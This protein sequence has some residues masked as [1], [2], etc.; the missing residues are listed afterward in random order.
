MITSRILIPTAEQKLDNK[1]K[2][3]SIDMAYF[4]SLIAA[5]YER[6]QSVLVSDRLWPM[7]GSTLVSLTKG[8]AVESQ[9]SKRDKDALTGLSTEITLSHLEASFSHPKRGEIFDKLSWAML[10]YLDY[11]CK[12]ADLKSKI[13][14]IASTYVLLN[15]ED[16]DARIF[17]LSKDY[18]RHIRA[19]VFL[20]PLCESTDPWVV[21]SLLSSSN[22]NVITFTDKMRDDIDANVYSALE[23]VN[24]FK[25]YAFLTQSDCVMLLG[26][27]VALGVVDKISSKASGDAIKA[28]L[29]FAGDL[30]LSED[31][32]ISKLAVDAIAVVGYQS[33][34]TFVGAKS[35]IPEN[36]L[37]AYNAIEAAN[38]FVTSFARTSFE[39]LESAAFAFEET[40]IRFVRRRG[41]LAAMLKLDA[42]GDAKQLAGL[43]DDYAPYVGLRFYR[44]LFSLFQKDAI[45]GDYV[46]ASAGQLLSLVFS[47]KCMREFHFLSNSSVSRG[48]LFEIIF[49]LNNPE[50][51]NMLFENNHMSG[52]Q[53]GVE[54]NFSSH[55]KVTGGE[56]GKVSSVHPLFVA[57]ATFDPKESASEQSI[58]GYK[59]LLVAMLCDTQFKIAYYST[60]DSSAFFNSLAEVKLADQLYRLICVR[61]D[62]LV[63]SDYLCPTDIDTSLVETLLR[64]RYVSEIFQLTQ[65]P[66]MSKEAERLAAIFAIVNMLPIETRVELNEQ[67]PH[68]IL[69]SMTHNVCECV[70]VLEKQKTSSM[71]GVALSKMKNTTDENKI[72]RV[73]LLTYIKNHLSQALITAAENKPPFMYLAYYA[74]FRMAGMELEAG[75][76][77]KAMLEGPALVPQMQQLIDSGYATAPQEMDATVNVWLKSTI[78]VTRASTLEFIAKPLALL[79]DDYLNGILQRAGFTKQEIRKM[80]F[81]GFSPEVFESQKALL[82][83]VHIRDSQMA[84]ICSAASRGELGADST[85]VEEGVPGASALVARS[86]QGDGAVGGS[87]ALPPKPPLPSSGVAA[88]SFSPK[89]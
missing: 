41:V 79:P 33:L 5:A 17:L 30:A 18:S 84:E 42:K 58:A 19:E 53:A 35:E 14:Q 57:L 76:V 78:F 65:D 74:V 36:M 69:L 80:A 22:V 40:A 81:P 56:G 88:A 39:S 26:N 6:S 3:Q 32:S 68:F 77:A 60:N 38:P 2:Q 83:A 82:T 86:L 73:H 59:Q 85:V 4:G 13:M 8:Q 29:M 55:S 9:W 25:E 72:A 11:Y 7:V 28:F 70:G 49:D 61:S 16:V 48:D 23:H 20:P 52:P 43:F 10:S 1:I 51:N 63:S 64:Q 46:D 37:S 27:L 66:D 50:F 71:F 75:A 45:S 62:W 21:L 12:D 24:T 44:V 47:L 34:L 87:V 54:Y 67:A 31:Q 15:E 89:G